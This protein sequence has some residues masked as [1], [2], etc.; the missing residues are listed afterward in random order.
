MIMM[1][2]AGP[3]KALRSLAKHWHPDSFMQKFGSQIDDADKQEIL[4]EVTGTFQVL[5]ELTNK[6]SQLCR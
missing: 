6:A 4:E 3:S 1:V 5:T 2:N